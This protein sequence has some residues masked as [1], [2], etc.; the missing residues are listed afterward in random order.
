MLDQIGPCLGVGQA[1]V[2]HDPARNG[3]LGSSAVRTDSPSH[4]SL[5]RRRDTSISIALSVI[6]LSQRLAVQWRLVGGDVQREDVANSLNGICAER[7]LPKS[8]KTDNG[9]EFISKVIDKWVSERGVEL[10]VSRPGQPPDNARV[11]SFNARRRQE[12]L[13]A[14]RFV[15][16]D[17]AKAKIGAR[18]TEYNA[19]RPNRRWTGPHLPSSPA[20][21]GCSRQRR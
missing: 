14:H 19:S 13:N 17:D 7:G 4:A 2:F 11:E 1:V 16:L 9:S 10:D 8:I 21:A 18:Q 5:A 20:L 12:C 6:S 3:V 15:S